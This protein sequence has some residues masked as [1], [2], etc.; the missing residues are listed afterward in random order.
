MGSYLHAI[1]INIDRIII[2]C[3]ALF[4]YTY[5]KK[6]IKKNKL[7]EIE[8]MTEKDIAMELEDK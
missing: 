6:K 4:T 3:D 1:K 8:K 7:F 5:E 2:I